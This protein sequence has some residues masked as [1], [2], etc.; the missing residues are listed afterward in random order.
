MRCVGYRPYCSGSLRGFASIEFS[1]L[2]MVVHGIT[3]HSHE[4]GAAWASPPAQA[5]N[6]SGVAVKDE[7][8]KVAYSPPLLEFRGAGVRRAW[9]DAVIRLV[10]AF[11]GRALDPRELAP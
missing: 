7:R 4:S 6:K 3:V 8:G 1:D 9:S 5:N 2:G 11:D 10:L